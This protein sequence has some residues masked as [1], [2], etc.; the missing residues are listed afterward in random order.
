MCGGVSYYQIS[1]TPNPTVSQLLSTELAL[2]SSGLV[3]IQTTNALTLGIHSISVGVKLTSYPN[4]TLTKT[5]TLTITA[6]VVTSA[7]VV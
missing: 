3:S 4:V 2:S 1:D 6:C 5:F 7:K